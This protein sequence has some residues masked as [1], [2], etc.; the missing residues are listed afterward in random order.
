MI[1][2]TVA[3]LACIGVLGAAVLTMIGRII[4]SRL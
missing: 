3:L 4:G 1:C 2:G